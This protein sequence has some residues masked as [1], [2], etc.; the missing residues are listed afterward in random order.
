M[1]TYVLMSKLSP[2]SLQSRRSQGRDWIEKVAA[3][4]PELSWVSHY[5]LLGPYDFMDVYEAPDDKTAFRVS[6]LSREL[7]AVSAESW[8]ALPYEKYLK[9]AD[10]VDESVRRK[11]RKK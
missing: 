11:K 1:P 6:L 8:P 7:G 3:L 5:A 4:C 10:R 2:A 9:I